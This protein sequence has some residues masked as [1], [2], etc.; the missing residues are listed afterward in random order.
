MC[1]QM[2]EMMETQHELKRT[3]EGILNDPALTRKVRMRKSELFFKRFRQKT[4]DHKR[5]GKADR[6]LNKCRNFN[7]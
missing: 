7:D 3:T 1:Q 2:R 4:K 5:Y 6:A